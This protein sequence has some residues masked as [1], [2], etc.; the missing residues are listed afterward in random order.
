MYVGAGEGL[1]R[2][3]KVKYQLEYILNVVF[4]HRV[5]L[6]HNGVVEY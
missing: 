1:I 5:F 6:N 4:K 3:T 2:Y